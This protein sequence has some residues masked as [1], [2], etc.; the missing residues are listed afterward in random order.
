M[1]SAPT[2]F[3][4]ASKVSQRGIQTPPSG[5]RRYFEIAATMKD[6]ISLGIG[7]PD[8]VSPKPVIDAVVD[9]LVNKGMTSY[10]ANSGIMELRELLASQLNDLYGV[11]YDP[12]SEIIMTVGGSEAMQ[13]A[14]MALLNPGDDILIP[15]P[16]FVSYGPTA[17]FAGA[18]VVYVPTSVENNF[19]VTGADLEADRKSVV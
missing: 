12:A 6:V 8:F 17:T 13:L 9:S 2:S 19:Q 15:E 16:C 18:N 7:E 10:T 1:M 4:V 5:I 14:M 3:D 11:S